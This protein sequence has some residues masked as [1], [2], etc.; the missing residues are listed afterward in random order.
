MFLLVILPFA[1]LSLSYLDFLK[2]KNDPSSYSGFHSK[3]R[4]DRNAGINR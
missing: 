4:W 1:S 2:I 3:T